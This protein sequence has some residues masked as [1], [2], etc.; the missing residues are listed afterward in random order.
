MATCVPGEFADARGVCLP[1]KDFE[2]CFTK[3]GDMY[4]F[5]NAGLDMIETFGTES[6]GKP[7]SPRAWLYVPTGVT[8]KEACV[9]PDGSG[10]AA[11][12]TDQSYEYCPGDQTIYVGEQAMW[13]FY[14]DHGDAAPIVA[15][16]HEWGHHL[17]TVAGMVVRRDH[18]RADIL[19]QEIQADCVA[20]AWTGWAKTRG[21]LNEQDDLQDVGALMTAIAE[22]G[23]ERT[24]GT[25][26]ERVGAFE[27]GFREGL[28]SCN[29]YVDQKPLVTS[30]GASAT[31]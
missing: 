19:A 20:G 25:L 31:P 5:F 15:L 30:A 13:E 26:E 27:T 14:S 16:A 17:Q 4:Y 28:A 11:K 24:H 12:Y 2:G 10:A 18:K 6:L 1:C 22:F 23:P 9:D 7:T 8:G 21:M 3:P 29:R